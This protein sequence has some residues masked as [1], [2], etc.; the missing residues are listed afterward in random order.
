MGPTDEQVYQD[1][2][3]WRSGHGSN[4][5]PHYVFFYQFFLM[6]YSASTATIVRFPYVST[7]SNKADFLYATVDVAIW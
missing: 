5:S 2:S 1:F 4:V 6:N 7:L 3:G